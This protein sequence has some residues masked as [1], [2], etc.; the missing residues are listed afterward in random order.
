MTAEPVMRARDLTGLV[1]WGQPGEFDPIK[2]WLN[3]EWAAEL[4]INGH[5]GL[6]TIRARGSR[7]ATPRGGIRTEAAPG[8]AAI[9]LPGPVILDGEV[10]APPLPGDDAPYGAFPATGGWLGSGPVQ[11]RAYRLAYRAPLMFWAFDVLQVGGVD[12]RRRPYAER[13]AELARICRR[14]LK[15]YPGCGLVLM[16]QVPATPAGIRRALDEGHEGVMLKRKDSLYR[17]GTRSA[18]WVKIKATLDID[19]W[20][21][22]E[23]RPGE[24][25]REGTT[26]SVE[27]AV[28]TPVGQ[29]QPVGFVGVPP[30]LATAYT[31]PDGGLPLGRVG[32]VWRI[33]TNGRTATGQLRHG[34]FDGVRDDK[35]PEQC[36]DD[37]MATLPVAA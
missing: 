13:R 21:T 12:W 36:G 26:G 3:R 28:M 29:V 7:L 20:L 32:E 8:L 34:R 10:T 6:L 24:G 27:V 17:P 23:T 19:A 25:G 4:K 33:K 14:I 15:A 37:Q 30:Q 22:G 18:D 1:R 16:P 2:G 5:R 9:R 11:A 31:D 35:A